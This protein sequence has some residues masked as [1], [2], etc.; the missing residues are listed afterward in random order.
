MIPPIQ[1]L[2][3]AAAFTAGNGSRPADSSSSRAC[4]VCFAQLK[5][6]WPLDIPTAT[7]NLF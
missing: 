6:E 1:D 2:G 7:T 4:H 5:D 3:Q